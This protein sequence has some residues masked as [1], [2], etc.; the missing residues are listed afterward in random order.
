MS[1]NKKYDFIFLGLGQNIEK[2]IHSFFKF[3]E[4]LYHRSHYKKI[5][6]IIGE[7]GSLDNTKELLRT[8]KNDFFELIVVDTNFKIKIEF[9]ELRREGKC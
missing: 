7:N 3:L 8:Y 1:N 9:L 6:M 2:T 4:K 5:C